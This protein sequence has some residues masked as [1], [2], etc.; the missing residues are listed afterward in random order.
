MIHEPNK[1]KYK[2]YNVCLLIKKTHYAEINYNIVKNIEIEHFSLNNI[3]I[4][5][6]L[7]YI[8]SLLKIVKLYH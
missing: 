1:I 8:Y 3:L 2:L 7:L 5:N 4:L 6:K